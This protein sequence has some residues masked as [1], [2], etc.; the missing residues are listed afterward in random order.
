MRDQPAAER[1]VLV[2]E[3]EGHRE[4]ARAGGDAQLL[5]G[6]AHAEADAVAAVVEHREH[7]ARVQLAQLRLRL[8]LRLDLGLKAAVDRREPAD[9]GRAAL[10]LGGLDLAHHR[11]VVVVRGVIDDLAVAADVHLVGGAA[12]AGAGVAV[13]GW[14][15]GLGLGQGLG[16]R[17]RARARARP[18]SARGRGLS[19]RAEGECQGCGASVVALTAMPCSCTRWPVGGMSRYSPSMSAWYG[20][21]CVADQHHEVSTRSLMALISR[22]W[23]RARAQ[24]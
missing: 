21:V 3:A 15:L 8:A 1:R 7:L 16:S 5:G 12:E 22:I 10:A 2:R 24:G 4:V 11:G 20:P 17:F 23:R 18:R 19:S 6:D 13:G 9:G 14:G